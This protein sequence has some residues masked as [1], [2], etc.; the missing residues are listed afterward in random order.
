ME[1]NKSISLGHE[2]IHLNM[3]PSFDKIIDVFE[4]SLISEL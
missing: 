2:L 4:R 1:E 3:Y